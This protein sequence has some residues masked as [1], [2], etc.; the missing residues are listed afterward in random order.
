MR[1]TICLLLTV[2]A[3]LQVA[4]APKDPFDQSNWSVGGEHRIDGDTLLIG[5]KGSGT[6]NTILNYSFTDNF[7]LSF[8]MKV[9]NV[10][11]GTCIQVLA[12]GV[13]AGFYIYSTGLIRGIDTADSVTA[14]NI[15][16][17]HEYS[18][19]IDTV[20]KNRMYMLMV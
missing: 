18:L 4:A 2:V 15:S 5:Q 13:R 11:S 9:N 16:D 1:S 19:V 10:T 7:T 6:N 12:G 20:E 17:W 3:P 8:F 14:S